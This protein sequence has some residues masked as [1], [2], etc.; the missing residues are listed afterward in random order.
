MF[1]G[2]HLESW[3][4]E[5]ANTHGCQARFSGLGLFQHATLAAAYALRG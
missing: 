5:E 1:L 3:I 4:V 2:A